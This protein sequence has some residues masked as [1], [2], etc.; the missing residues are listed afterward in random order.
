VPGNHDIQNAGA[1]SYSGD[2]TTPVPSIAPADFS[3]IYQDFGLGDAISRDPDSLSYVAELVPGL[4]LLAL[5]SCIYGPNLGDSQS[6]PLARH[7]PDLDQG[8]ARRGQ[9]KPDPRDR[10]DAPW[11]DRTLCQSKPWSSPNIWSTTATLLRGCSPTAEWAPVFTGHFTPTT[12][13]RERPSGS[14]QSLFDIETG[15]P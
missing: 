10:D 4:W 9:G 8:P 13:P 14:S 3:T 12:L 11:S 1:A 7:H 6:R 5:D 2:A 15:Q